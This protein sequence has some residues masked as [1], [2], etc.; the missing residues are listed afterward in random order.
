MRV[1]EIDHVVFN[2][3]DGGWISFRTY[4]YDPRGDLVAAR[5]GYGNATRQTYDADHL[6]TSQATPE[7]RT[8]FYRYDD[9]ARCIETW[10]PPV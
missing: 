6:L 4:E 3:S 8:T 2:V 1:S 5:D 7:G 10:V 9:R